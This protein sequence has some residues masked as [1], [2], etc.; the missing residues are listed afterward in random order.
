MVS[1]IDVCSRCRGRIDSE[2]HRQ[3]LIRSLLKKKGNKI[4]TPGTG[5][6][7]PDEIENNQPNEHFEILFPIFL[8]LT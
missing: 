7:P 1:I 5:S 6:Q 3:S 4:L 2:I 8:N